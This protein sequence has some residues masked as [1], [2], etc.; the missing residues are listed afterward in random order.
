MGDIYNDG[1]LPHGSF[2]I[3]CSDGVTRDFESFKPNRNTRTVNQYNPDGSPKKS[4]DIRD[5][6]TATGRIQVET[7]VAGVPQNMPALGITITFNDGT[8]NNP[9]QTWRLQKVDGP[10]YDIGTAWVYDT[11]WQR[12]VN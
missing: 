1:G 3:A 4:V 6:D 10:A 7:Q 9:T 5:F 8:G 12:N 11:T 2:A